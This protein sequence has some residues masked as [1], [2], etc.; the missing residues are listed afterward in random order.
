MAA[1]KGL[2]A[3]L[4]AERKRAQRRQE[5][6]LR[7]FEK[8]VDRQRRKAEQAEAAR[9][10]R[11][12]AKERERLQREER[13]A[14]EKAQ[15]A[16]RAERE[17]LRRK[18]QRARQAEKDRARREEVRERERL[19]RE[20]AAERE[21]ARKAEQKAR[22]AEQRREKEARRAAALAEVTARDVEADEKTAELD[23]AVTAIDSLVRGRD[24]LFLQ[25]RPHAANAFQES[26]SE[27]LVTAAVG[28][29]AASTC[30]AGPG[31]TDVQY[32]V[33]SSE[34][35]V[36]FDLPRQDVVPT[37]MAYKHM[38]TKKEI[39]PV[40]RPRREVVALYENLVA[41]V[42]LRI[43]AELFLALPPELVHSIVFN[44]HVSATDE[45]TGHPTQPVILSLIASRDKFEDLNLD[46]VQPRKCLH[47]LNAIVSPHPFDLEPVRPVWTFDPTRYKFVGDRD[48]V[49]GLDHRLDLLAL[50]PT[51]F[52]HLMR[53][54][55]EATG[56]KSWATQ[57]SRDEG[58]DAIAVNE[59]PVL[60][61]K[62]VI[63]AKRYS[64]IV[65][66][67]S[68]YAL[69]GVMEAHKASTGILAATSYFGQGSREFATNHGRMILHDGRALKALLKEY[70]DLDVLISLEKLP[71]DWEPSVIE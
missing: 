37:L 40:E 70:L 18:E 35:M 23:R 16:A 7:R 56:L 30:P 6:E 48:A 68:V 11:D 43:L 29:L 62:C 60:F 31:E 14:R 38:R 9:I 65:N 34:L 8:E 26:G 50:S 5:S 2:L 66:A 15:R 17:A 3:Q 52:E 21:R 71:R 51:E 46:E 28:V 33:D 13:L 45:A 42:A 58:I 36:K 20:Q 12:Q 19:R 61:G 55:Y 53:R 49:V 57:A 32:D 59:D 10:R 54:L 63:Q 69:A 47:H 24:V 41:Q 27:G 22:A 39:R 1:K 4:Y 25:R 64:R 44:G 67:E